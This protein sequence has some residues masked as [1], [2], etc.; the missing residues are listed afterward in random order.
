[1]SINESPPSSS[2]SHLLLLSPPSSSPL[3]S[4]SPGRFTTS[5]S[6]RETPGLRHTGR[7]YG[8]TFSN[9]SAHGPSYWPHM[10]VCSSG[11]CFQTV[12][13]PPQQG[14]PRTFTPPCSFWWLRKS[15]IQ[16]W[17]Y[18][19][20]GVN[21]KKGLAIGEIN[22]HLSNSMLLYCILLFPYIWRQLL[23]C[24]FLHHCIYFITLIRHAYIISYYRLKV[25]FV[26]K[27]K[28]SFFLSNTDTLWL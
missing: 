28:F 13:L 20:N 26:K 15:Q 2:S 3:P 22:V 12:V 9:T 19:F 4:P 17:G 7:F 21:A 25:L 14:R 10:G 5:P 18:F 1:M 6:P 27:F 16:R 11:K 24:C 8:I 23:C